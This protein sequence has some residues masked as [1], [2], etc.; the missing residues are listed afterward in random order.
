[1]SALCATSASPLSQSLP[2]TWWQ[3]VPLP[4]H[5]LAVSLPALGLGSLWVTLTPAATRSRLCQPHHLL[6][7]WQLCCLTI[8]RRHPM[9]L[10]FT[11]LQFMLYCP[12]CYGSVHLQWSGVLYSKIPTNWEPQFTLPSFLTAMRITSVNLLTFPSSF[13]LL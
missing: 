11:C 5:R 13:S 9:S 6:V 1:M 4:T 2:L 12:T 8:A 10:S 7:K 3:I